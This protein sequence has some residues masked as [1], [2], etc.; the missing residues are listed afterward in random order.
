MELYALNDTMKNCRVRLEC[1]EK[2][3][4]E[5]S[6]KSTN[7]NTAIETALDELYYNFEGKKFLTLEINRYFIYLDRFDHSDSSTFDVSGRKYKNNSDIF[8]TKNLILGK[9]DSA[10][11]QDYKSFFSQL[12]PLLKAWIGLIQ[13]DKEMPSSYQW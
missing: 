9:V 8:L 13:K 7:L 6:V 1:N 4:Y 12:Q 2:G 5:V 10:H 11:W 3:F